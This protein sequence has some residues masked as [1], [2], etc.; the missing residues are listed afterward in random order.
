MFCHLAALAGYLMPLGNIIGPLIVWSI[1]K[2]K[3]PGVDEHGKNSLN[4]QITITIALMISFVLCFFC[5]GIPLVF[6]L[7]ITDIICVVIASVQASNG[8]VFNYPFRLRFIT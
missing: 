1:Q 4:F 7:L 6:G 2:D 8:Q 3:I 5:I